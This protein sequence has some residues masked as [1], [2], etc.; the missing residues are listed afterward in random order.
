MDFSQLSGLSNN[1]REIDPIKIFE[2]LP[3]LETTPNDIWR[4]QT[5]ALTKWHENRD[6]NDVLLELNTG[7][8]KTLVGILLAQSLINEGLQNVVYVCATVDL[9][10]Q[11]AAEADKI[12]VEYTLRTDGKYSNTLFESGRAFCITTYHALFNGYSSIRRK[13]FPEAIIFDDAH[14]S[15]QVLRS[16]FTLRFSNRENEDLYQ[17]V[18]ALFEDHFE[19]LDK[20]GEF[21]N[22]Q[23]EGVAKV[24]CASPCGIAE[25]KNQLVEI[26]RN[27][28]VTDNRELK[29][30][31]EHIKDKLDRCLVLFGNGQ[32]EITPPFL[33]AL[34]LDCLER[35]IRRIYLSA[36]L[37][38]KSDFV[39]AYGRLPDEIISPHNDAGNGERLILSSSLFDEPPTQQTIKDLSAKHKVLVATPSYSM[40]SN[41][42]GELDP[43]PKPEHFSDE[44]RE[45]REKDNGT[46]VLVQRVDGIDLPHKTCRIMV[47]DGLPTG[48]S[49]LEKFQWEYLKMA[50]VFAVKM[51]NRLAQLFGRINRGRNDYGIFIVSDR[52]LATWLNNDRNLA[53]LPDL[54]QRQV[55]FGR[56]VQEG[57]N[58]RNTPELNKAIDSVLNRDA[59]WLKAYGD[60]IH[61]MEVE[62]DKVIRTEDIEKV[63]VES[64]LTEAEFA[65]LSWEGQFEDA[66]QV[67]DAQVEK[68]LRADTPLAGWYNNILGGL[69]KIAGDLKKAEESYSRAKKRL[70]L[71]VF[72]PKLAKLER[73]NDV[74]MNDFGASLYQYISED[75][76]ESYTK[77]LK[78]LSQSLQFLS[79]GTSNQ[80]EESVR[81]FGEL[82]GFQASRPDNDESTGPDVLWLDNEN[83][84]ALAFELKTDK[85]AT[86]LLPKK[87]IGQ[88]HDHIEWIRDNYPDYE[89]IAMLYVSDVS[90]LDGKATPNDLMFITSLKSIEQ[91]KNEVVALIRD[92][93]TY[94][95][96]ERHNATDN[97]TKKGEW[98]LSNLF[99]RLEPV[100]LREL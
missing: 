75:S 11:T 66:I 52:E 34:S 55:I 74:P 59:S 43:P 51:A 2:Q 96:I 49:L 88:G 89:L 44:L 69:Y 97:A 1:K 62:K 63:M 6:K 56:H 25:R 65:R 67:L 39:R 64:A 5:E 28:G 20:I 72:T 17:D 82:L 76:Q 4:G 60:N 7:A 32:C 93:R 10:K 87:D 37:K 33:P 98:V 13:F 47:L 80:C 24:V 99:S 45:F 48:A 42:W 29:Y 31:F 84:L 50:N 46:F 94:L 58:I 70:G 95:P 14:V 100:N 26:L 21:R 41:N 90:K 83:K 79:G 15:E 36:T 57:M 85:Q 40:A 54:I 23:G 30:A 92:I 71:N 16:C 91:L 35:P 38:Y 68:T 81:V 73:E 3:N 8:G 86:G 78:A 53:L 77:K 19:Q 9:V 22:A 61:S 27:H 12:G 18:V